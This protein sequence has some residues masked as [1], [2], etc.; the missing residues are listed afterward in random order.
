[1]PPTSVVVAWS[2]RQ[3]IRVDR[4]VELSSTSS[5]LTSLRI[6]AG[7]SSYFPGFALNVAAFSKLL[8]AQLERNSCR[9]LGKCFV[10]M[11]ASP[12]CSR[13]NSR[14]FDF[15]RLR[16][17][18]HPEVFCFLVPCPFL[19]SIVQFA[20]VLSSITGDC[21]ARRNCESQGQPWSFCWFLL[22]CHV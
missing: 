11:C 17:V 8:P 5:V 20:V 10:P 16:E 19:P 14:H 13:R 12:V 7:S 9:R 4:R 22:G 21:V 18:L 3:L 1:M 15:S 2:A 6:L